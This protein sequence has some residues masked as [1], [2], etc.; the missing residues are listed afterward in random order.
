M[1]RHQVVD[2]LDIMALSGHK[3]EANFFEV[4]KGHGKEES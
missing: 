3:T 2:M 1:I 4:H